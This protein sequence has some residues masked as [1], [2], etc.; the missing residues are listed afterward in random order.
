MVSNLLVQMWLGHHRVRG[1]GYRQAFCFR[2]VGLEGWVIARTYQRLFLGCLKLHCFLSVLLS[3][4][5]VLAMASLWEKLS[6]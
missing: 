1:D 2:A 5:L 4:S 3:F 6:H